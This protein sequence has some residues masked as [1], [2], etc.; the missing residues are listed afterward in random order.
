MYLVLFFLG[1]LIKLGLSSRDPCENGSY[2]FT[3]ATSLTIDKNPFKTSSAN[4]RTSC[5]L[6]CLTDNECS[7]FSYNT[8]NGTCN[9]FVDNGL[10]FGSSNLI[11]T[12][13]PADEFY[14][15]LCIPSP[16]LCNTSSSFDRYP[17]Y[18]L[19]GHS[20]KVI[21]QTSGLQECLR[22]CLEAS[23]L[24][25]INCRSIMFNYE[26]NECILNSMTKNDYPNLFVPNDKNDVI[27]YFENNCIDISCA[28]GESTYWIEAKYFRNITN[29][30]TYVVYENTP[31]DRCIEACTDNECINEEGFNCKL[32]IYDD[33]TRECILSKG[34]LIGG[35]QIQDENYFYK[36]KICLQSDVKCNGNAFEAI[37]NHYLNITSETLFDISLST[38]LEAC[39]KWKK[40][41]TSVSYDKNNK[42]CHLQEKSRFSHPRLFIYDDNMIYFDNICEYDIITYIKHNNKKKEKVLTH[43]EGSFSPKFSSQIPVDDKIIKENN[44][45]DGSSSLNRNTI[46]L[47]GPLKTIC[48]SDGIE[49]IANFKSPSDGSIS[50]KDHS[51][52]CKS[53]FSRTK[54]AI[55]NIPYPS[56]EETNPDCP[57][58]EEEP[59]KWTFIVVV[60]ENTNN[61]QGIVDSNDQVFKITCDYTKQQHHSPYSI[62]HAANLH[63]N[64]VRNEVKNNEENYGDMYMGLYLNDKPVTKVNLGDEVEI[65]WIMESRE[66]ID[67]SVESCIAERVDGPPPQPP[68]LQLYKY[69]CP[70][71]KVKGHLIT[72]PIQKI[73]NGYSS[74]MKIFRFEGSKKVRIRCSINVCLDSCSKAICQDNDNSSTENFID[75]NNVTSNS[76]KKRHSEMDQEKII[77]GVFSIIDSNIL[78]NVQNM[79]LEDVKMTPKDY[80]F[81]KITFEGLAILIG[82]SFIHSITSVTIAIRKR[83]ITK[84]TNDS[85]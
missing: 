77:T 60:Q 47:E 56:N 68:P 63:S 27:D 64:E 58:S 25:N 67:Y 65:R 79:P 57:G 73:N 30:D 44:S 2:T 12:D 21:K 70:D 83:F 40:T 14:Q 80:C 3:K 59:G 10:P 34:S 45:G 7:T 36:E 20:E 49:V 28:N 26:N 42:K 23:G 38:C 50:I 69:G 33:D 6:S 43:G 53:T 72:G 55:L 61:L 8:N 39:L 37:S 29:S 54:K 18:L 22:Y 84:R 52:K 4:S 11:V 19:L 5:W 13:D 24:Y 82:L 17:Q 74:T 15:S 78:N 41:C 31:K 35:D 76:I 71:S 32:M 62:I 1:I 46:I 75:D 16:S 51:L 9:L 66:K 85:R 81:S 48:Q